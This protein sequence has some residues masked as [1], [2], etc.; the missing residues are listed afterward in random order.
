MRVTL[1]E[2]ELYPPVKAFLERQGY[3]VKAEVGGCDV[4]A[5][6]SGEPP[7]VVE[8]KTGFTLPLIYQAIDRL[9]VTDLVYLAIP[10]PAKGIKRSETALCRRLGLGL[11]AVRQ[12]W[13]EPYLDPVPYA[14]RKQRSRIALLLKEFHARVGDANIG[15]ST[16]RPLV[17]AYRQDALRCARFLANQ[18]AARVAD[19]VHATSVTRA[20]SILKGNVYGWFDKVGRG[21]YAASPKGHE[22]L[23]AYSDV[24]AALTPV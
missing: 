8:L 22:A 21:T 10:L 13:V 4:M 15:G 3:A 7:V 1:R 9:A 16:R 14:P 5:V 24:V 6:R 11:L 17:T 18:G 23:I 20:A 2:T 12:G 19:V